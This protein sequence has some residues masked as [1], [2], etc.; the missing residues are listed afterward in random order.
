MNDINIRKLENTFVGTGEVADF[1]FHKTDESQ[2]A[3]LFTV[4]NGSTRH[5][6]VFEK[7]IV[8]LCLDFQAKIF[9]E[10]DFK[11]IY[12]KSNDFG[13]WAY[14]FKNLQQAINKFN[15]L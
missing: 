7:K 13:K 5:Y 3:Y 9:S 6:E 11:E 12:P 4:R 15:S 2:E 14:T 8:P 10:T 1:I